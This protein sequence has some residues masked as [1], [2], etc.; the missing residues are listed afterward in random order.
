MSGDFTFYQI[1]LVYVA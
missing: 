1:M